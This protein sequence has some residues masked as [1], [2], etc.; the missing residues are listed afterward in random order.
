MEGQIAIVLES[1]SH[2]KTGATGACA[3]EA[4]V[5]RMTLDESGP[6]AD[7]CSMPRRISSEMLQMPQILVRNRPTRAYHRRRLSTG[8]GARG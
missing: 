6:R 7:P 1:T 2:E 8:L 4:C 3:L 5:S